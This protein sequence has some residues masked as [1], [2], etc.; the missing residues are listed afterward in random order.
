MTRRGFLGVSK[1]LV[2]GFI[3]TEVYRWFSRGSQAYL[4]G[5]F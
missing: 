2:G 5:V 1:D 3:G 4:L